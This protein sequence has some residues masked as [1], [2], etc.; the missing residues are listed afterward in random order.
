MVDFIEEPVEPVNDIQKA[1]DFI[2]EHLPE[3][4]QSFIISLSKM[5][6]EERETMYIHKFEC[7]FK[8]DVSEGVIT[9][10]IA[11]LSIV[12]NNRNP[13]SGS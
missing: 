5:T 2:W 6:R 10:E 7:F 8:G 11:M 3:L 9:K 4:T 1:K 13:S 12:D